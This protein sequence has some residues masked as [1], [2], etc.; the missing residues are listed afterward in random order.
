[1][2]SLLTR[3]GE[4]S[5]PLARKELLTEETIQA[6]EKTQ[7][8]NLQADEVIANAKA[9]VDF[10]CALAMPQI[11]EYAFPPVYLAVWSWL[12]TY[13]VKVRD[14]SQ[15]ALGLPRGFSKTTLMKLFCLYCILFTDRKFILIVGE[16]G[17][18]ALAIIADIMDMLGELNIVATFGDYKLGI[19][20]DR[21]ELKKFS[22]RGR[23][24]IVA[25]IG[26]GG[27][28]RGLNIKH[29]RP[30]IMIFDDI[31]SRETADSQVLSE[32]L[33]RWLIGT[34][35]KSKSPRG[36]M[37][38]FVANMY[39]TPF[40]ILRKLKKNK[41]WIK[42]ICGGILADGSSLW[43]ELQPIAQLLT[44]YEND[45]EAGHPEIFYAEVLNDENA[46]VNNLID[47]SAL[48]ELPY[49][50]GD[51]SAGNFI[52]IDPST[53]K[54]NSDD[55]AIGYFEVYDAKPGLME[56]VHGKYSPME[57][58]RRATELA[59]RKNCRLIVCEGVAYQAT[60]SY[61]FK[62]ICEQY[63]LYGLEFVEI[64]PGGTSKNSRILSMLKALKSGE[65]FI[66][67]ECKAEVLL[68]AAQFNP[69]RRDNVDNI[70]DL[71]TY[72]P[73]VLE[74][75]GEYVISN[76]IIVSQEF[77]QIKVLSAEELSS[78]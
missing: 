60:L 74:L 32:A 45:V 28:P 17:P 27:D 26:S 51:I 18:K 67:P 46:S 69:L 7:D 76:T 19:E 43:E 4:S 16:S 34:T 71:V 63:G 39:P 65:L 23:S 58:I 78:F 38:L 36:C 47:F 59:L 35:M 64:Y 37:F 9:S 24:I 10:L 77:D 3:L 54:V 53:G 40:S 13:V 42:F 57:T 31:Q 44:E 55:V 73:K 1:M 14:F 33:E 8:I 20:I 49:Q 25:G 61:W 22:F 75:F 50:G 15:L 5:E 21:Q 72:A 68:E 62:Y 66:S 41:K 29:S 11:Y 2:S 56:V 30:D 70:L 12:L 52:I 48:P 6:V